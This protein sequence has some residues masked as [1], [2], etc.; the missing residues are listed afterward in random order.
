MIMTQIWKPSA[1][2]TV[3]KQRA[4]LLEQ[5]RAFF[6]KRKVLEIDTP[7]LCKYAATALHIDPIAAI[8]EVNFHNNLN[9][10]EDKIKFLQ[11]SPEYCMKRFLCAFNTDIFQL[12]KAFR[13]HEVGKLHNPEFTILEWYRIGCD[14][15]Q[16]MQEIQDLLDKVLATT[17]AKNIINKITYQDIFIKY[18]NIDPLTSS[19]DELKNMVINNIKLSEKFINNIA[20]STKQD[21]QELLFNHFIEPKLKKEDHNTIWFIYNY[22]KEQAALAKTTTDQNGIEVAERF[23]VYINGIEIANGYHELTDPKIQEERFIQDRKTRTQ[24]N[25]PKLEIDYNLIKALQNGMPNCSGVA[26]G[27][28]RLLMIK[29]NAKCIEE[30]LCFPYDRA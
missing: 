3:V 21:C 18:L 23:E 16:L 24:L 17:G 11:T 25:K 12:C 8:D 27:I 19:L 30:V 22:P 5:I 13:N 26:L 14:H 29:I 1:N 15:H 20:I 4:K 6:K 10:L 28:D 7:L 2:L 9:I